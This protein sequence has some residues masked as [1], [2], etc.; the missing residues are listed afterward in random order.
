MKQGA[1]WQAGKHVAENLPQQHE[2]AEACERCRRFT[3]LR[4]KKSPGDEA[5]ALSFIA[6]Q[7][8]TGALIAGCGS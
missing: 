3:G 2:L 8:A 7:M 4:A 6:N 5:R 1:V